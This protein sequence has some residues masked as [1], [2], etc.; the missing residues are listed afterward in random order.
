MYN[1]GACFRVIS[2]VITDV[3]LTFMT[4][5]LHLFF[6]HLLVYDELSLSPGPRWGSLN[7]AAEKDK[8][9]GGHVLCLSNLL[10]VLRR[11]F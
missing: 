6:I 9:L 2:H 10:N 7:D 1:Q 4:V 8:N 11:S 5:S 3:F